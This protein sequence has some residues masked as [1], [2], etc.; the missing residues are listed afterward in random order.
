MKNYILKHSTNFK[1]INIKNIF[2]IFF[3]LANFYLY[4]G[5]VLLLETF[6]VYFL[7]F[8][9]LSVTNV[10]ITLL[11][12]TSFFNIYFNFYMWL[13]NF[14]FFSIH[15]IYFEN[16]YNFGIGNFNFENTSHVKELYLLFITINL[17][18]LV[19]TIISYYFIDLE[20]KKIKYKFNSFCKKKKSYI[21][22]SLILLIIAIFILNK[23]FIHFDYYYFASYTIHP[24]LASF[25]KW[26]FLF[27]FTSIFCVLIDLEE[28]KNFIYQLFLISSIQEFLF[29]NS[30]LSRG[31]LFN[32][33]AILIG[34]CAKKFKNFYYLRIFSFLFLII[35]GLFLINFYILIYERGGS[36][37]ENLKKYRNIEI[38]NNQSM[39]F[40]EFRLKN[41]A[42]RI[43]L[44]H[45]DISKH[46]II[47]NMK[48]FK[49]RANQI[50]FSFK[51][52]IFGADSLMVLVGNEN[53]SFKLIN[54]ALLEKYEP[55]KTSY[56]DEIR[57]KNKTKINSTNLTL[58]S[59]PGFLYY[60]G[61]KAFV[62][63]MIIL[64]IFLM[65]FF[66]KLNIL[67]NSNIILTSLISQ[68]L[69]YR[70]WHFGYAPSN[71][72]KFFIAIL[73]S[74]LIAYFF[75]FALLRKKLIVK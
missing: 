57:Q 51:N 50:F 21:L 60:S 42:T 54:D 58:P 69:A 52:R 40:N 35:F 41:L 20:Y 38:K 75:K 45:D 11:L 39:F 14:F 67:L 53:K 46:T 8:F 74:V 16:K 18:I 28:K 63:F 66:E 29:Y 22:L 43:S 5:S 59:L 6:N 10:L 30:I 27:G 72:Y 73:F 24:I 15:V 44:K 2:L 37:Y 26:F 34:L 7:I 4:F 1:N 68:L 23:Y 9:I 19:G 17:A 61:S 12:K 47:F 71:S 36:N 55:G 25:L 3:I 13:G 70:L 62:F 33:M 49:V 32:S 48:E 31:C 65:N 64:I 56:F